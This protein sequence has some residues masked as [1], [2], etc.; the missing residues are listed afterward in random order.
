MTAIP[1]RYRR[2]QKGL[3]L[4]KLQH[5][6]PSVIVLGDGLSHLQHDPHGA[7]LALGA[8]E[9]LVSVLVIG[10]VVRGFI[11]LRAGDAAAAHGPAH[12]G[13]DWIDLSLGAMLLVEAYAKY[14]ATPD[15][16]GPTV[17]LGVAMIVLGFVHGRIAAW[18][19]RRLELRVDDAGISV[20]GRFFR[21]LSLAW[22]QVAEIT[23]GPAIARVIALDGR[24]QQIDLADAVNADALR[25]ALADAR[26]RLEAYRVAQTGRSNITAE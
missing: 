8:A 9:V 22:P 1:V 7:S 16:P 19:D 14:H 3:F 15:L 24:D 10:T 18:G 11:K 17:L 4:Q 2:A 23:D 12:H 20:P 6:I 26:A 25:S 5:A 21:R 13:V